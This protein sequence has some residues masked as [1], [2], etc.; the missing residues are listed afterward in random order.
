MTDL[1][2]HVLDAADVVAVS[3]LCLR[4]RESRDLGLWERMADCFW[5]DARV[6]ISWIDG[7]G[8]EFVA[9]SID[10]AERGVRASHRLGPPAVRLHGDRAAAAF[11]GAIDI[12]TTVKGV[13]A[14]L[15]STA[16]FLYRAERRPGDL[17][18]GRWG[19]SRFEAIYMRDEL[20]PAVPG[21]AIVVAPE[22]VAGF[23]RAYRMLSYLLA[24]NGYA[25]NHEL[26]GED[27]PETVK[28]ILAETDAW[29]AGGD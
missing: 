4:E 19:L 3:Q 6:K 24:S 14:Y 1:P 13:D 15:S 26:P 12:P 22:E 10:M 8:E 11:I 20:T 2:R 5:P 28:A 17:R 16:R 18:V 27:R 23:R 9:G 25:V 29:L 21:Q 7:T